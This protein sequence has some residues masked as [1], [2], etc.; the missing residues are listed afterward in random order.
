MVYATGPR[1]I[2]LRVQSRQA[3]FFAV[4]AD[5]MPPDGQPVFSQQRHQFACSQARA[6]R[7]PFIQTV[8]D[9]DF[10]L[11]RRLRLIVQAAVRDRQ[12]FG[13]LKQ[14]DRSMCVALDQS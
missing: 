2:R 6:L 1:Q 14:R 11:P 5:G 7:V 12:Q 4:T 9:E 13:L 3:H 8:L 10:L